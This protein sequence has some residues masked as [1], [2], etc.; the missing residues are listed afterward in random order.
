[1]R[2]SLHLSVNLIVVPC[3]NFT[4][5]NGKQST[6][7]VTKQHLAPHIPHEKQSKVE[8]NKKGCNGDPLYACH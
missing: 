3:G 2:W 5:H 1:M 7:R 4:H 8:K 6:E